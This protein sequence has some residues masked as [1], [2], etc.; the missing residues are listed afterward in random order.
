MANYITYTPEVKAD[1]EGGVHIW[2]FPEEFSQSRLGDR[3][4]G[5][6]ACTLIA[7]LLAG[8]IDEF[9]IQ[10][11]GYF[12]QPLNRLLVTSIAEAI[13]EGNEIHETLRNSGQLVDLNLTVP[14]ALEAVVAKY[15]LFTEWTEK[16][17]VETRPMGDTLGDIIASTFI[18][19]TVN[20]PADK[21]YGSDL[22]AV[23]VADTRS[24]LF[25]FQP[26]LGKITMVDSHSH[27]AVM[28][29][30]VV[31]QVQSEDVLKLCSWFCSMYKN[32][33]GR[34]ETISLYEVA[35]LYSQDPY[36]V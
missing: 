30:A 1:Q 4:I 9:Q 19:W 33:F 8:R 17:R 18:D 11:W 7:V 27:G 32:C 5:S 10:I 12:D 6:N 20:P 26:R 21:K 25:I 36:L 24:V 15:P 34:G 16:T 22:F 23:L 35:F 3:I 13:I 14:E 2:W 31:A 29:G 28:A